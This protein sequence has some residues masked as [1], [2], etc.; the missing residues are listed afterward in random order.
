[1][2]KKYSGDDF[3]PLITRHPLKNGGDLICIEPPCGSNTYIFEKN[4]ELLMIDCG[5]SCYEQEMLTAFRTL[6]PNFDSMKKSLIITHPDLDHCGLSHLF[7]TVYLNHD[8]YRNFVL[9]NED[10][11]NFR[12]ENI[13]HAPYY[14]ISRILSRYRS[15]R[16]ETLTVIGEDRI[17]DPLCYI[18]DFDFYDLHF[19]VYAGNGG[20]N[21]GEIVLCNEKNKLV[22]T[23]DITVNIKGFRKEQAAFNALAPYLMTSVN[24]NSPLASAERNAV[25][26][27]FDP[28]VYS[29]CCG[30]GAIMKAK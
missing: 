24:M 1:M 9:E 30:H 19:S 10:R 16:L 26:E 18:G 29:Y 2:L 12:E 27:K 11:P 6:F 8:A 14:H 23:G 28:A 13:L 7:D 4:N 20:H 25:M 5:F 15:P 3:L 22:F 21:K 17:G